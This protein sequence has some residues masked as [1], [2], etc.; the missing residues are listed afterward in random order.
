MGWREVE[1]RYSVRLAVGTVRRERG[2]RGVDHIEEFEGGWER[3]GVVVG[4][5]VVVVV[6]VLEVDLEVDL[7]V[8]FFIKMN[9]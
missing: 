1:V 6:V 7:E 5:E 8:V 3:G 2:G 4:L 9:E